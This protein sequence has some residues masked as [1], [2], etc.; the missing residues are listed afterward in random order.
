MHNIAITARLLGSFFYFPMTSD[1]NQLLLK[2]LRESEDL[3]ESPFCDFIKH[4]QNTSQEMLYSDY[5]SLFEGCDNMPA[6]PWGSVYLD[7]EKVIFGDSTLR[8]RS[9]LALHQI[10]VDTGMRE[11]EDQFGLSLFAA[12][13]LIEKQQNLDAA[14]VLFAEHLLPWAFHYL[15]CFIKH[16]QTDVY[17]T[18]AAICR[19]WLKA[20]KQAMHIET[21]HYQL[22]S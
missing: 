22:Y 11:P 20:L 13:H 19:D 17:K 8:L 5:Q 1:Y 9:F 3:S 16:A 10:E 6:P 4:Y 12:A 18:L 7:R 14:A 2:E 15:D 21:I